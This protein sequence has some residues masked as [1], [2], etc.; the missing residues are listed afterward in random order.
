MGVLDGKVAIVTGGGRGIGSHYCRGLA[1]EGARVMV[2]DINEA[3][4]R[5][6]A[7]EIGG[8]SLGVDVADSDSVQ[9]M[10]STTLNV[11]GRIDILINNAAIFT[12]LTQ[13]RKAFDEIPVDEWDRV[14]GVNVRGT[15]L[16]SR[17][18]ML[19]Q[20]P[21]QS[22]ARFMRSIR[23]NRSPAYEPSILC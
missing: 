18:A 21:A 3:G 13:P 5:Q 8:S 4:A 19:L 16:C 9:A 7:S 23:I 6:V 17:A 12:E 14:M 1:A 10:V 2:A 22:G 11:F 15:W 20:L